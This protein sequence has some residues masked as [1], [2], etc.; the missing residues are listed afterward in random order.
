MLGTRAVGQEARPGS[1]A[2]ARARDPGRGRSAAP[3]TTVTAAVAEPRSLLRRIAVVARAE[4]TRVARQATEMASRRAISGQRACRDRSPP[5]EREGFEPSRELAPPTRLAGE[6]LQPLGHLSGRPIVG[7]ESP[8]LRKHL[9]RL[10]GLTCLCRRYTAPA[11]GKCRLA[12]VPAPEQ[13]HSRYE[14]VFSE[15]EAPFAFVDLDAMWANASDMARRAGGKPIRL[16]TKSVRCRALLRAD[17]RPRRGLRRTAH[18]HPARDALARLGGIRGP[19]ARLSHGRPRR[20]RRAGDREAPP[21]PS[22]RRW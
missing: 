3:A 20:A 12:A 1:V 10:R 6:C 21:T 16:A 2:G 22:R 17:P 4:P 15:V 13:T 9:R 7:E 11:F 14:R 18:L 8:A 5:A 19:A